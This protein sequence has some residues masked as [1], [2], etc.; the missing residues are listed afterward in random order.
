M[1]FMA[2]LQT[3]STGDVVLI[4]ALLLSAI[5]IA[6]IRI[7]PWT[8]IIRWIGKIMIGD[9][10]AQIAALEKNMADRISGVEKKLG[11]VEAKED[12]RDAV[13]KRVRILRF[14]DELQRGQFHTKDSFDQVLSCDITDY[15]N[16]C[17]EHPGFKNNQTAAT[18][19]HIKK[20]YAERLEK[21]DFL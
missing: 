11:E 2:L 5:Q 14:E 8:A 17:R 4:A 9:L 13:N 15:E 18:V 10:P 7:D 19:E 20:I 21:R 12:E 16:Y 1:D 3:L 6:P